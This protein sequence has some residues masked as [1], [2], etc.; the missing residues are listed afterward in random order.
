M[1]QNFKS[2]SEIEED[3]DEIL[4]LA[5]MK[6]VAQISEFDATSVSGTELLDEDL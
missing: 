4:D 6:E 3:R 2:K 5:G 1:M